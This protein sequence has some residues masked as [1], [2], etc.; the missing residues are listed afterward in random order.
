MTLTKAVLTSLGLLAIVASGGCG[1]AP[2]KQ[3]A[4]ARQATPIGAATPKPGTAATPTPKSDYDKALSYTRCMTA[5]GADTPDPVVGQALVTVN[6]VHRGDSEAMLEAKQHAF[7]L[8]KQLLPATWPLKQDTA[9]AAKERPFRDCVRKEGVAWPE[10]DAAGVS[11]WPTDPLAM[12]TP[13]YDAAI[14][15][16]R[17]L[18]DDPANNLPENQ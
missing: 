16:C 14:R 13:A 17:H 1:R 11:N 4:T 6:I 10:P 5:N 7:A 8:C 9:D 2:E 18:L 3:V 15:A 12:T